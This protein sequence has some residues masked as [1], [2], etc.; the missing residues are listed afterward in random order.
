[1][2]MMQIIYTLFIIKITHVHFHVCGNNI[3]LWLPALINLFVI[4][5][6]KLSLG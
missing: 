4:Q 3:H 6:A 1:M 5:E 2:V